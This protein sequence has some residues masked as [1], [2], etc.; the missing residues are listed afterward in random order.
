MSFP[1]VDRDDG[2]RVTSDSAVATEGKK[3]KYSASGRDEGAST[4]S[5]MGKTTGV[6]PGKKPSVDSLTSFGGSKDD[7]EVGRTSKPG[8]KTSL[9][10]KSSL[11]DNVG[12]GSDNS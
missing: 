2:K 6:L 1:K 10:S 9:L 11:D 8:S 5:S 7:S 4:I 12:W 3:M